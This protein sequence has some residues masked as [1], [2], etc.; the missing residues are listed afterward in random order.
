MQSQYAT[1][2]F[3][4]KTELIY[5]KDTNGYKGILDLHQHK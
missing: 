1:G 5:M 4:S 2:Q 3:L